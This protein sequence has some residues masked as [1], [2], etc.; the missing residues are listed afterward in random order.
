[1]GVLPCDG[2]GHGVSATNELAVLGN[3]A[4]READHWLFSVPATDRQIVPTAS[5]DHLGDDHIADVVAVVSKRID[6]VLILRCHRSETSKLKLVPHKWKRKAA[7]LPTAVAAAPAAPA[8]TD[9]PTTRPFTPAA[10]G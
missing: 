2:D 10:V 1:M 7:D 3:A 5:N 4:E 6:R 9:A 8:P